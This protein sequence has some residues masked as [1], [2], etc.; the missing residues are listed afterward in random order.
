MKLNLICNKK[1]IIQQCCI[2]NIYFDYYLTK[3]RDYDNL[4]LKISYWY[5]KKKIKIVKYLFSCLILNYREKKKTL[6]S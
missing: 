1:R 4:N 3:R 6:L 5:T 2:S